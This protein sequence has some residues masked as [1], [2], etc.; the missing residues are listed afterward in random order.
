M[1]VL[2]DNT[3]TLVSLVSI[4]RDDMTPAANAAL[5][6]LMPASAL[7]EWGLKAMYDPAAKMNDF[8]DIRVFEPNRVQTVPPVFCGGPGAIAT[9]VDRDTGMFRE[10]LWGT[11]GVFPHLVASDT[12]FFNGQASRRAHEYMPLLVAGR[13]RSEGR[14]ILVFYPHPWSSFLEAAMLVYFIS[15]GSPYVYT[16]CPVNLEAAA[17]LSP[18]EG[19]S[20][21]MPGTTFGLHTQRDRHAEARIPAVLSLRLANHCRL[22]LL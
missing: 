16:L 10:P 17:L 6:A 18:E 2:V 19:G 1:R 7:T 4:T 9:T 22:R 12:A 15:L 5:I 21:N 20:R 8:K 14:A 11:A 13:Q 3:D